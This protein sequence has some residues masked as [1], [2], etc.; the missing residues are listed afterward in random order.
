MTRPAQP[1][2]GLVVNGHVITGTGDSAG[3]AICGQDSPAPLIV[4]KPITCPRCLANLRKWA[5]R[6]PN[7]LTAGR[8]RACS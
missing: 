8:G 2:R 4:G 3:F 7:L 1:L 6:S 5:K